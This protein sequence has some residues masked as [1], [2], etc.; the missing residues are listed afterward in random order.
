MGRPMAED[1]MLVEVGPADLGGAL[2]RFALETREVCK[3]LK[4]HRPWMA[5]HV[6]PF[7]PHCYVPSGVAAQWRTAQGMHW[8]REALRRLV[9]E[10]ATF[11][12]RNRRVYASAHMPEQLA[13]EIAAERDAL[14]Y[15][16]IAAQAEAGL[17]GD[18]T[19]IDGTVTTITRLLDAFDR[20][21]VS[22]ALDA[23]GKRLW[24]LAVIR[25]NGLPWIPAEPVSFATDGSWQTTASM[26]DWGDTSEMVQRSIFERCMTRVEIDFPGGP[27]TKIMYFDDPRNTEEYDV[28]SGLDTSWIVPADA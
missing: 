13:V 16:A 22:K 12:R 5:T 21:T 2:D 27:G 28:A 20:D 19:V 6:R 23:E 4:C 18:M 15:R 10:H 14:Q 7:V 25:R 8:D 9:A 17:S 3:A 1:P 24:D 11:T 26:T